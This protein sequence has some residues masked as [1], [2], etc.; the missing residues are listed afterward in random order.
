MRY[1]MQSG[2]NQRRVMLLRPGPACAPILAGGKGER[3]LV[4]D[5][6]FV[7][8]LGRIVSLWWLT[9]GRFYGPMVVRATPRSGLC[10]FTPLA[11]D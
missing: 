4:L 1:V 3:P 8:K 7:I 10:S 11:G 6:Q 9:W 2:Q 5:C